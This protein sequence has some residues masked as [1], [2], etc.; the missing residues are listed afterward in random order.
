MINQDWAMLRIAAVYTIALGAVTTLLM[1]ATHPAA[2]YVGVI[3]I[4]GGLG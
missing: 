1:T 2:S 3:Q 4:C